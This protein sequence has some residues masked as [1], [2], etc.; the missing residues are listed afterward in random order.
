MGETY[1]NSEEEMSFFCLCGAHA[2]VG[3]IERG[4]RVGSY[5]VQ[6]L[7][8]KLFLQSREE[9]ETTLPV[10][11]VAP[12]FA[13]PCVWSG[14]RQFVGDVPNRVGTLVSGMRVR[15]HFPHVDLFRCPNCMGGFVR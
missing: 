1:E 2:V 14:V 7:D 3:N 6:D 15:E 9:S 13:V 12:E 5:R 4:Y 11:I 10:G 8:A